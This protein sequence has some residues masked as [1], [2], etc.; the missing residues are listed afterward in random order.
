ML[1]SRYVFDEQ[2]FL[3]VN[4]HSLVQKVSKPSRCHFTIDHDQTR[5][6]DVPEIPLR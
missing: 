5:T 4:V 3:A 2:V 1:R 6:S